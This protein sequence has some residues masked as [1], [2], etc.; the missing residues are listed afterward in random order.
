LEVLHNRTR[1][2][3]VVLEDIY[4]SQ[5]A[6]AA[7]RT[8]DCF[9][10]QDLHIVENR[11]VY[12][13]NPKVVHGASKWVDMHRYE[14]TV[15]NTTCC[16]ETLRSAGYR[17]VG[18]T[19]SK[20]AKSVHDLDIDKPTALVFGTE[21]TGL[22][23]AAVGLCDEMVTY[24]MYGFTESLNIS[25]SVSLCLSSLISRL[26]ISDVNWH[27]PEKEKEA[28]RLQWYKNSVQRP[29]ILEREF[30]KKLQ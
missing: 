5:N 28:L 11:H 24:P 2:I 22:S 21:A 15:N 16:L 19:P 30:Y 12:K 8:C 23:E 1:Y 14:E 18:T 29:D 3:T 4:Q 20:I 26:R 6:S 25:V 10:V 13:L 7:V 9:G 17:I 27:L